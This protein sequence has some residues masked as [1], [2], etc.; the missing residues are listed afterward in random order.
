MLQSMLISCHS[1]FTCWDRPSTSALLQVRSYPSLSKKAQVSLQPQAWRCTCTLAET[2]DVLGRMIQWLLGTVPC[3][4]SPPLLSSTYTVLGRVSCLLCVPFCMNCCLC[5]MQ[6][7]TTVNELLVWSSKLLDVLSNSA[8][9]FFSLP[10]YSVRI[11]LCG[12]TAGNGIV[13][14]AVG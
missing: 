11:I 10:Y 8:V 3:S 4:M 5:Y 6:P 12:W 9:V 7:I 14:S 2:S 1:S 13:Y